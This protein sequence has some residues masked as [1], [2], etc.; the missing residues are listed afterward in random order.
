MS[1]TQENSVNFLEKIEITLLKNIKNLS[2]SFSENK[3]IT[4]IFG[5]NGCGKSTILY[6]LAC[7]FQ[8]KTARNGYYIG[9]Q[10]RF[11]DFFPPTSLGQW[12]GSELTVF[13]T[14][15]DTQKSR[16]YKKGERWTRYEDRPRR[17]IY[18]LGINIC[19]PQIE[20]ETKTSQIKIEQDKDSELKA[21]V[22]KD[23]SYVMNR[24]YTKISFTNKKKYKLAEI[25][26]ISYPS[27]FMGAGENKIIEI[28]RVVHSAG[29]NSLILIDELDLTLHT[30]ALKRLLERISI[31]S[32]EKNLQVIFT[33]HREDIVNFENLKD[34]IDVKYITNRLGDSTA[35]LDDITSD[36]YLELTGTEVIENIIYVEDNIA[37]AIVKEFLIKNNLDQNTKILTF[38]AIENAF[39]VACGLFLSKED[40]FKKCLFILDGDQCTL[41]SERMGKIEKLIT[42]TES[43]AQANRQNV[44]EKIIQFNSPNKQSPEK[45]IF[46]T[47]MKIEDNSPEKIIL[48]R[49]KR[50]NNFGDNHNLLPNDITQ[51]VKIISKFSQQ[52]IWEDYTL[53][54]R[55]N[56]LN[57]AQTNQEGN[58]NP[59]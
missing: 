4:A 6:S 39:T 13:Y 43:F 27:I 30:L 32:N 5:E 29:N 16:L 23:I 33:S 11:P 3:R 22:I 48:E 20:I 12:N 17:E 55:N 47:I 21:K 45:V 52:D 28:L 37:E 2:I 24:N 1:L 56:L 26:D 51:I 31:I 25:S 44:L 42:G 8:K 35:C 15:N 36:M 34:K 40:S 18:F 49:Q 54:L 19:V 58:E 46:D 59:K 53:E 57:C 7:V 38:G 41:E 14:E 50:N 10:Y 9:E